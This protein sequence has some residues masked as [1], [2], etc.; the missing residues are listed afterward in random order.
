[1]TIALDPSSGMSAPPH[2][3]PQKRMLPG[4]SKWNKIEDRLFSCI[5]MSWR[6]RPL[7]SHEVIVVAISATTT[8]AGLHVHAELD[9]GTYPSGVKISDGQMAA[10]PLHRHDR[11]GD[12]NYTLRPEPQRQLP[13]HGRAA[14]SAPAG[15]TPP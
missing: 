12:W 10:L 5:T 11:H 2:D 14:A 3:R 8:Y 6:G 13:G 1:V 9:T 7:T 15:R 4:T